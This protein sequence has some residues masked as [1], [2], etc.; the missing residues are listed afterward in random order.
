[1]ASKYTTISG[2]SWDAIAYR[3]YGAEKYMKI[4]IEANWPYTDV[5]S[6][7]SGIVLNVPDIPEEYDEDAPFWR[8]DD[9]EDDGDSFSP[10]EDG[11]E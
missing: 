2:D 10:L 6:F 7:P 11:Y 9:A 1:M 4:L 8:S 5:L 3:L